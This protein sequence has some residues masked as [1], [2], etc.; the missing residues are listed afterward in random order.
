MAVIAKM[1][2]QKI[3]DGLRG[4]IDF[5]LWKGVAVARMWPY[6]PPR[7]PHPR[8]KANQDEWG[9]IAR[10]ARTLP[11]NIVQ[12]YKDMARGTPYTWRDLF[13]S[14]AMKVPPWAE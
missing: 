10:A 13:T 5:Y 11:P 9:K 3:V 6:W 4:V 2:N 12:A 14:L 1:P 8:E 7:K